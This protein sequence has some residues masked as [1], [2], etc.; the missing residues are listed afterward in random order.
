MVVVQACDRLRWP[1]HRT[2]L[3][4]EDQDEGVRNGH[5][6]ETMKAEKEAAMH[7]VVQEAMC[8]VAVAGAVAVPA[9]AVVT[10]RERRK[11]Y[12]VALGQS[13]PPNGATHPR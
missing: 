12:A 13:H 2:I 9:L 11:L 5:T 3:A 1:H 6:Q 7:E 8:M 10:T 4:H